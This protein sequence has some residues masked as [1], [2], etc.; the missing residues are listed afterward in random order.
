MISLPMSIAILVISIP[1]FI[2]ALIMKFI[3]Y[4]NIDLLDLL[5]CHDK[6][7][8]I[9]LIFH[10]LI[11]KD[12]LLK[13]KGIR[14]IEKTKNFP[15]LTNVNSLDDLTAFFRAEIKET[16]YLKDKMS[17]SKIKIK[18]DLNPPSNQKEIEIV[19]EWN[20][21]KKEWAHY[22]FVLGFCLGR[23]KSFL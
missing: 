9:N 14:L 6:L 17:V 23:F 18:A 20:G 4:L 10:K 21:Y 16:Y 22:N 1:F 8:R 15:A 19:N 3:S 5:K 11:E 2:A 13:Y 12:Q 7:D